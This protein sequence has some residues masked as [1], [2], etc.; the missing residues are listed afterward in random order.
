M[1]VWQAATFCLA[2]SEGKPLVS[3][4]KCIHANSVTSSVFFSVF[5]ITNKIIRVASVAPSVVCFHGPRW[6]VHLRLGLLQREP[7]ETWDVLKRGRASSKRSNTCTLP[8]V[9]LW[10]HTRGSRNAPASSQLKLLPAI[11]ILSITLVVLLNSTFEHSNF[12]RCSETEDGNEGKRNP[13]F[14]AFAEFT[15]TYW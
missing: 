13:D 10:V 6:W 15:G 11:L 3:D 2:G 14:S 9:V 1:Q 12:C 7:E 5:R 4:A 8:I